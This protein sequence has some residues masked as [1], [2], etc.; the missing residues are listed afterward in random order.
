MG[1]LTSTITIDSATVQ[2]MT[3]DDGGLEFRG[4]RY[5]TAER[6]EDP[7]DVLISENIDATTYGAISPQVPG[8]LEQTVGLDASSMSDDCL[9]LNVYAPPH[10]TPESKLPVLFWIHGG[11][12][13]NGAGSLS[14]YHGSRLAT[15]ECIV[16]TINYRLGIFGFL[17]S[18]NLG[19]KDMVSALRWTNKYISHF[20]GDAN[21]VTIFGESAGGSAVVSLMATPSAEN[22]FHKAWAMSPSIGQLRDKPRALEIERM[23]HEQAATSDIAVLKSMTFDQLLEIQNA[24]L[25]MSSSEYDWFSPTEETDTIPGKILQLASS[26]PKPF[27]I[28]TNKDENKLWA[29]FD[30]AASEKTEEDWQLHLQKI[31]GTKHNDAK[32]VY[33]SRRPG[34]SPHFLMSA[35]NTDAG[36]RARAWSLVD[37]RLVKEMPSWMYWFTWPTPAFG[38]ILGSCHALDIPFAFDN[39]DAPGGEMLTGD[40]PERYALSTRFAD[41]IAH[42]ALHGHPTWSQY[43]A[44]SRN[45]LQLDNHVTLVS[46]PESDIRALFTSR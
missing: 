42:F 27:V 43:D 35:V 10:V 11:A 39:L 23:I 21:N 3:R 37:N 34:E 41:E 20:G 33:E 2:G 36:F 4:I 29:A 22:L 1:A 8:F 12:Y 38:G 28:G 30:P 46:D 18:S 17:G 7:A 45:T 14:W 25:A 6:F 24:V 32:Q 40:A 5:A 19:V 44:L 16:V 13:T 15:R 26:S 31:F 9:F